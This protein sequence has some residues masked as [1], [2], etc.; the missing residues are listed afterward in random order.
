VVTTTLDL[1]LQAKAQDAVTTQIQQLDSKGVTNGALVALDPATGEVL[2]MVGSP[3]FYDDSLSGQVNNATSLNQPGS[4]IK[5]ITYLTTFLNGWTPSTPIVDEPIPWNNGQLGNAD[6]WYRGTVPV[7]TALASS[8]N[9]PA[10]KA[11]QSVGLGP[12]VDMA[13]RLGISTID[14]NVQY[15]S[16]FTLGAVDVS[17]LDMTYVYSTFANDGVQTGMNSVLGLPADS[18]QLD[19]IAVLKVETSDGR[20]IWQAEHRSI[21]ATP[22]KETFYLTDI[23]SDDAARASMFGLNSPLQLPRPAAVKSGSSDETRDAWTIGY[24]PQLVAGVWVGNANNAPIPNGTSTYTAAPIWHRFMLAAL[25]GQPALAFSAP[26]ETKS[27]G[28]KVTSTAPPKPTNVPARTPGARTTQGTDNAGLQA[29][30]TQETQSGGL[31]A[32]QTPTP[33]TQSGGLKDPTR[34][35]SPTHT[36]KPKPDQNEDQND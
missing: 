22:A 9:V 23:L 35:P 16:A 20:L 27:A 3:D 4:T 17:L 2:A 7:R 14:D 15:G 34:T 28:L 33:I 18:R 32:S 1:G 19:P 31:K 8:L 5:P 29:T 25:D 24:T 21:R 12:V 6:G 13:R 10:V 26:Q 36:P 11:L 30:P